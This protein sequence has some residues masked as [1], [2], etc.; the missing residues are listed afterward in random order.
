MKRT[1]NSLLLAFCLVLFA[2]CGE[3][4]QTT[5]EKTAETSVDDAEKEMQKVVDAFE[6]AYNKEDAQGLKVLFADD[7]VRTETDGSVL[8]GNEAISNMFAEAFANNDL[9]VEIT[10]KTA[11]PQP[12]GSIHSTGTYH[13]TGK[14]TTGE[15]IDRTGNYDVIDVKE[16]G[17]W[18]IKKQT[19]TE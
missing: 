13:V 18:K 11:E 8:N 3:S 5:E 6:S 15:T 9:K 17:D 19:L 4:A 14:S 10:Q 1:I 12:D 7:A 16:D 2:A